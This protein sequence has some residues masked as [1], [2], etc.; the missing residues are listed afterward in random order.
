MEALRSLVVGM[1]QASLNRDLFRDQT[2]FGDLME[3]RIMRASATAIYPSEY[4]PWPSALLPL[5]LTLANSGKLD[6]NGPGSISL[7]A[8]QRGGFPTASLKQRAQIASGPSY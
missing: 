4:G 2:Q 1:L 6:S 7:A 3:K 8:E 5:L